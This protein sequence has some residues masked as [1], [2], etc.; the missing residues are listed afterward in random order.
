[1]TSIQAPSK[2]ALISVDTGKN[3]DYLYTTSTN[4]DLGRY[5]GAH[6]IV[7]GEEGLDARWGN[8][9]VIDIHR[10]IVLKDAGL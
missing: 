8:T 6:V 9:P 7:V 10:L 5:K 2:Y 3:I 4:L 1:M